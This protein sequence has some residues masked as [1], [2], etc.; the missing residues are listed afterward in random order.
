MKTILTLL[1]CLLPLSTCAAAKSR[2]PASDSI[3][4]CWKVYDPKLHDGLY[5]IT[6]PANDTLTAKDVQAM[7]MTMQAF[8]IASHDVS[9]F[10]SD[11]IILEAQ[12]VTL[13]QAKSLGYP[14]QEKLEGLVEYVLKNDVP[15][16]AKGVTIACF[17]EHPLR[18][19]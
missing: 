18:H 16:L 12:F 11:S 3:P 6:I 10:G 9:A 17:E 13:D 8:G 14:T 7:I 1:A 15:Y 4:K 2:V 5:H 19:H